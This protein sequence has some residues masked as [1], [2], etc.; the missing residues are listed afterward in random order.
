MPDYSHLD[1]DEIVEYINFFEKKKICT[2]FLF[3]SGRT[4]SVLFQSFLDNH[5]QVISLPPILS[6]Y[7]TWDYFFKSSTDK[8]KI[9]LM[10][11][12][13]IELSFNSD[14]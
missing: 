2:I 8:N 5:P 4:G 13:F 9:V 1:L 12:K 7:N 11:L 10:Y 3:M 14:S 6:I